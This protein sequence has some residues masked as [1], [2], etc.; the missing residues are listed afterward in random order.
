[1]VKIYLIDKKTGKKEYV[2][3]SFWS[4]FKAYILGAIT[5]FILTLI[6][7]FLYVLILI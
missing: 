1:M 2:N 3:V 6:I 7:T 5:L 4:I